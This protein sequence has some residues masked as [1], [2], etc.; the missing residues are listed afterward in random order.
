[1]SENAYG[2]WQSHGF[3]HD[4]AINQLIGLGRKCCNQVG[5]AVTTETQF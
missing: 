1:M 3:I 4:Y 2:E 5:T